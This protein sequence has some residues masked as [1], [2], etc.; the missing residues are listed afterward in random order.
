MTTMKNYK[1][2]LL[3]FL[4]STQAY[5]AQTFVSTS[6]ENKKALVE[7]FTGINCNYC[8]C[9]DVVIYGA[10]ENNPENIIVIKIHEGGYAVP[11][12][13]QPDFRTIYGDAI[14]GQSLN[15]G[16]PQVSVNRH[17]FPDYSSGGGTAISACYSNASGIAMQSPPTYAI[18]QVLAEPA[19][20][21][22][23]AQAEV[24]YS[25][26]TL[27]V[28][29]EVYYTGISPTPNNY[30]NIAI[31]Q[32]NT[33]AYQA[34]SSLAAGGANF[35][36]NDR[37]VDLI[38]GQWGEEITTAEGSLIQTT[39]S[40]NIPESYNDI[41]VIL[42]DIKVIVYV[43]ESTQEVIN[44]S[45]AEMQYNT[46]SY[47]LSIDSIDSPVYAGN[48]SDNENVTV[49][50]SNNGDNDITN[51]EMSYDVDGVNISTENFTESI[52]SNE[53]IQFTFS[54]THDFSEIGDYN[55]SVTA[56]F[57]EDENLNNNSISQLI[58]NV[59]GGD[60]P[61]EYGPPIIWRENF[62]CYDPF[63]F[64]NI[65][66]WLVYD[67][68][69]L[70]T[71]GSNAM[72][73]PSETYSGAGFIY[74]HAIATV[75]DENTNSQEPEWWD[76]YEGNQGLYFV[77][78][79]PS[80]ST[81]QN[82][83]WMISPEFSLVNV[84]SPTLR[85]MAKTLKDDWGLERFKIAIGNTTNYN[86]F[87]TISE[88]AYLEA[89]TEWTLYE[90]DLSAYEGQNIRIGINYLSNDKFVL[91]MDEFIVEGTLGFNENEILNF[92]Y[93]YNPTYNML[94]LKSDEIL[95]NIKIYNS[96]GQLV[97]D[98]NINNS[99]F[100]TNLSM[101]SSSIYFVKVEGQNGIKSF[102]LRVR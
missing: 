94:N 85:F 35:V 81:T 74:N 32:D 48:L 28:N 3:F 47:D 67:I 60:C 34:G 97:I 23:A 78:G 83:D 5:F 96:I 77:S 88:G 9:G 49:T 84:E 79:V 6:P 66:D 7:K 39:H 71:Y 15:T 95:K 16:N 69:Q 1:Y 76:T 14:S 43:T 50:I 25:T 99:S 68:D 27:T 58:T 2:L 22:I 31:V 102:K 36:H 55:L 41:P 75:S 57:D 8:P 65:G 63:I 91:Q 70:A 18:D 24:N 46:L 59:G 4:I 52:S 13:G 72:D 61:D 30:L 64:E 12:S 93:F 33:I 26:N 87:T 11:G 20:L 40:Y 45:R 100:S 44:V 73:F 38:T 53:T 42:D 92:E 21:N 51:F 80:G 62:E 101:L 10:I 17:F 98:E 37:L 19:Y 82:N 56:V 89:P 29:T 90:F 54:T 86:D